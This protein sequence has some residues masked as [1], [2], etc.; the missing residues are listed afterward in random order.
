MYRMTQ[1]C[2][3]WNKQQILNYYKDIVR[4]LNEQHDLLAIR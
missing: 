4:L 3:K 1:Q 2:Q